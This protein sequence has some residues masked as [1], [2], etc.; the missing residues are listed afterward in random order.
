MACTMRLASETKPGWATA[1]G[2]AGNH[3]GYG[4]TQRLPRLVGKGGHGDAPAG[5]ITA[6]EAHRIGLADEV[7]PAGE[8]AGTR[9]RD[10]AK[11]YCQCSL[12]VGYTMEAVNQGMK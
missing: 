7:L 2:E 10:R 5:E 8:F 11:N 6:Q 4:G 9:R 12:A 1:R 3:P